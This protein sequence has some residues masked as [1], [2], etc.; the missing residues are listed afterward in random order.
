MMSMRAS[1]RIRLKEEHQGENDKVR[2]RKTGSYRQTVYVL[3]KKPY[4]KEAE[5]REK[6]VVVVVVEETSQKQEH[7]QAQ[8]LLAELTRHPHHQLL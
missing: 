5:K 3:Q 4:C 8:V 7:K 1:G 2:E 6:T